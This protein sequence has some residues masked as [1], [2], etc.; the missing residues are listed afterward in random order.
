MVEV[1]AIQVEKVVKNYKEQGQRERRWVSFT[2][3][4]NLVDEPELRGLILKFAIT[5][6]SPP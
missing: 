2:E 4:Q 1:F 5:L 6:Q 3:A